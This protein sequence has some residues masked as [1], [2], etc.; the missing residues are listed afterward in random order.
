MFTQYL[1]EVSSAPQIFN[2]ALRK[3]EE[4]MRFCF[5]GKEKRVEV[6]PNR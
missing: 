1:L 4:S 3:L 6:A 5:N 2:N